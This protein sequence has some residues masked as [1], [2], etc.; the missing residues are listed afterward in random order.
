LT[1]PVEA[2]PSI[3]PIPS[4]FRFVAVAFAREQQDDSFRPGFPGLPPRS[5]FENPF[6]ISNVDHLVLV[7]DPSLGPIEIMMGRMACA[8]ISRPGPNMGNA[9]VE[10]AQTPVFIPALTGKYLK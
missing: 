7:Q 1:G 5:D 9:C 2:H 8:G 10:Y 4:F 6:T 3:H